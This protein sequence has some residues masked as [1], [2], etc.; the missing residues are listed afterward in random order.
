MIHSVVQKERVDLLIKNSLF[1]VDQ[2][3]VLERMG[4]CYILLNQLESAKKIYLQLL[5][6]NSENYA[7]YGKYQL[8]CGFSTEENRYLIGNEEQSLK[9]Y[10]FYTSDEES[11]KEFREKSPVMKMIILLLSPSD[12]TFKH[13]MYS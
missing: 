3:S 8:C 13:R 5:K 1:L 12:V 9:L 4:E 2:I 10:E 11:L 7:Y 6:T